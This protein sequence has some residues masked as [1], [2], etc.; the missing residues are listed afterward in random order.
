MR[1]MTETSTAAVFV[2]VHEAGAPADARAL[3]SA[4]PAA[5]SAT[6]LAEVEG[7]S[8]EA[9]RGRIEEVTAGRPVIDAAHG[10]AVTAL[11][12]VVLADPAAVAGPA[13]INRALEHVGGAALAGPDG[14]SHLGAQDRAVPPPAHNS[15]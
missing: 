5:L 6:T 14:F 7:E 12:A 8:A 13:F 1:H 3:V 9:L 15:T 2:L 4:L 11:A 10:Q